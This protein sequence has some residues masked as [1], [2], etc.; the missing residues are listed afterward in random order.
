[1]KNW[2]EKEKQL[3]EWLNTQKLWVAERMSR[4]LRGEAVEDVRWGPFS[5]ELKTRKSAPPQYVLDW[6]AQAEANSNGRIPIVLV[7]RDRMV[8]GEQVVMMELCDL[9]ALLHHVY[10]GSCEPGEC[11]LL[12]P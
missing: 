9:I 10:P 11:A 12:T 4:G 5:V 2:K 6:L 7:H 3:V 8:W 1:M